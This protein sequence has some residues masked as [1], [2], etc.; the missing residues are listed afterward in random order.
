MSLIE[1]RRYRNCMSSLDARSHSLRRR[2]I[3]RPYLAHTL[4]S[5]TRLHHI[6]RTIL[7]HRLAP[8]LHLGVEP[9]GSVVVDITSAVMDL[10]NS[11]MF[12]L[13]IASNLVQDEDE[14]VLH[15]RAYSDA[16]NHRYSFWIQELPQLGR[17]LPCPSRVRRSNSFLEAMTLLQCSQAE[18]ACN[19]GQAGIPGSPNHP[20]LYHAFRDAILQGPV[21]TSEKRELVIASELPDHLKATRDV[22]SITLTHA[23]YELSK[24]EEAQ[25]VLRAELQTSWQP[26][27]QHQ[28]PKGKDLNA[29]P[30]LDA[31]I[32]ET[33]R[34]RPTIPDGQPR[35]SSNA[36]TI[37]GFTIPA[38]VRISAY[39]YLIHHDCY[40]FEEPHEWRPRRW[41]APTLDHHTH[42][43]AFGHGA[44]ECLGKH[45]ATL[46]KILRVNSRL[47]CADRSIDEAHPF[48]H[49]HIQ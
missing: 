46:C 23:L 34:L 1:V 18:T 37:Q 31:V 38:H 45:M 13:L 40:V 36:L 10:V 11:H 6:L 5:S 27:Q 22:L 32:R 24:N 42:S 25:H 16:H 33:L 29:L 19:R 14:C 20:S 2:L 26:I 35:V 9:A 4:Q 28:L 44:R 17:I 39:P 49:R 7:W 43:W 47:S 30:F 41:L 3:A 15:R 21:M 8:R 12:G 48:I